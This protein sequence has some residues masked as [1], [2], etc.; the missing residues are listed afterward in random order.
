MT[1]LLVNEP[2][3]RWRRAKEVW[4]T[5][6]NVWLSDQVDSVLSADGRRP[7]RPATAYYGHPSNSKIR[8]LG[9]SGQWGCSLSLQRSQRRS[10]SIR[11]SSHASAAGG[12]S[13]TCLPNNRPRARASFRCFGS[14]GEDGEARESVVSL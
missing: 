14:I 1:S 6:P 11:Y 3:V 13:G 5:R 10:A 9:A 12:T 7:A 8:S 2:V 4:R